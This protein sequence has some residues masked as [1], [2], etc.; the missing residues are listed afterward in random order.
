M[1]DKAEFTDV[2]VNGAVLKGSLVQLPARIDYEALMRPDSETLPHIHKREQQLKSFITEYLFDFDSTAA[3]QRIGIEERYAQ[4]MGRK[5][6]RHID[7]EALLTYRRTTARIILEEGAL[8]AAI[9]L[10]DAINDPDASLKEQMTAAVQVLE[11]SGVSAK[12]QVQNGT[13]INAQELAVNV[14]QQVNNDN[15]DKGSSRGANI[16]D[17]GV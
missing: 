4:N 3:A 2:T 12:Q 16:L 10:V 11:K 13:T 1:E 17:N 15:S 7:Q 5:L 6:L 8:G 14:W 9:K